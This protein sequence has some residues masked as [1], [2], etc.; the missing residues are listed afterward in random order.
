MFKDINDLK[1]FFILF[2]LLIL[3]INGDFIVLIYF[4][5]V[6]KKLFRLFL[7]MFMF[8]FSLNNFNGKVFFWSC[9]F[10]MEVFL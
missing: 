5:V 1:V 6:V 4:F 7:V 10:C 8:K 3:V 2:F 9:N